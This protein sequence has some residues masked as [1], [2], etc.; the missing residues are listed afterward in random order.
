MPC[1]SA[2]A[3]P[4]GARRSSRAPVDVWGG[5]EAGL[6]R[7][8]SSLE[9]TV[10]RQHVYT[11]MI[12]TTASPHYAALSSCGPNTTAMQKPTIDTDP[13]ATCSVVP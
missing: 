12:K 9:S 3:Y 10:G 1:I 4:I 11:S 13:V 6:E 7:K 8:C 5:I 2:R